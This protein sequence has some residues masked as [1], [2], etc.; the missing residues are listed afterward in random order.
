[1]KYTYQRELFCLSLGFSVFEVD[2]IEQQQQL[3]LQW[4]RKL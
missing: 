1:M 3:G 2:L 4:N